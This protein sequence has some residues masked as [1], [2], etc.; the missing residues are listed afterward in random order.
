MWLMEKICKLQSC[1]SDNAVSHNFNINESTT[2]IYF[3]LFFFLGLHLLHTEVPKLGVESVLQLPAY[4][5]PTATP[6]PSP[7]CE[8]G[9]SLWP[10]QILNPVSK[11]RDR[12]HILVGTRLGS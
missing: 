2:Y 7:T 9:C 6:D 5:T 12:T 11:A 10:D 3:F 4:V 8:Y 1:M